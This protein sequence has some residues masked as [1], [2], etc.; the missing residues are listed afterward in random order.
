MTI[1]L[2]PAGWA[3]TCHGRPAA[4]RS[5]AATPPPAPPARARRLPTLTACA[6]DSSEARDEEVDRNGRGQPTRQRASGVHPGPSC[7]STGGKLGREASHTHLH[8]A[9]HGAPTPGQ[10]VSGTPKRPLTWSL[11]CQAR[12]SWRACELGSRRGGGVGHNFSR[13]SQ[14]PAVTAP[15][16]RCSHRKHHRW[17]RVHD[18]RGTGIAQHAQGFLRHP[19]P[20]RWRD[21]AARSAAA[22]APRL[23][24]TTHRCITASDFTCSKP[25]GTGRSQR[26]CRKASSSP[27]R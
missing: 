8:M 14:A 21:G 7:S 26:D 6:H 24:C 27:S 25:A 17:R 13:H 3:A 15:R 22:G 23:S 4:R 10:P 2:A 19:R 20:C 16:C 12:R 18:G 9:P 1:R 5:D 11:P